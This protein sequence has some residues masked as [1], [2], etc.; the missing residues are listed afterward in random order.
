[1]TANL[2][3]SLMSSK[4]RESVK[5]KTS[6][7]MISIWMREEDADA[8]GGSPSRA[9]MCPTHTQTHTLSRTHQKQNDIVFLMTSREISRNSLALWIVR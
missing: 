8:G 2:T 4:L 9:W 6:L 5:Q 3:S 7:Q 1:M